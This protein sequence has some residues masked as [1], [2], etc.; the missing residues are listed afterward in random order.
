MFPEA[1]H[2]WRRL[3]ITDKTWARFKTDFATAHQEFRDTH[4]TANQTGYQS[5]NALQET[6]SLAIQT[7]DALANLA[8]ATASDCTTVANQ[9]GTNAK[10]TIELTITVNAKLITALAKIT[11]LQVSNSRNRGKNNNYS[12]HPPCEYKPSDNYCWSHGYKVSSTHSSPTCTHKSP[13]HKHE[14][15]RTNNMGGS[16]R[17]RE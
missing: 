7:A 5:A 12:A 3:P 17:G 16:Q 13:G 4:L 11:E 6:E 9:T 15:T 1:C 8:T 2:D 10:L 14:A